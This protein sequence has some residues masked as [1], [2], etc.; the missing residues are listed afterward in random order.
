MQP[1]QALDE[2]IRRFPF[3]GYIR[4]ESGGHLDVAKT[5]R[6]FLE[7]G[8]KI[9]DFG[10]GP[11]DKTA[12]L[13]LMGYPCTAFDDLADDWIH[14]GE[15]DK[16]VA[17]CDEIGIVLERPTPD[18]GALPEALT[19]GGFD[20][21]ML[22][23]VLEHLHDSPRQ[24]LIDL[25]GCVKPNGLLYITVP[26]AV[27][28]R[29]RLDVLRGRTNA[30]AFEAYYW[31]RGPWRGHIREY[32]KRDLVLLARYLDLEVAELRGCHHM[33]EKAPPWL[34]LIY[35]A[36]TRLFPGWSDSWELVARKRPTWAPRS[37]LSDA[38]YERA[39]AKLA[40]T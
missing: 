23:D 13:Q 15:L 21:V 7:P 32:A 31:Y 11:C 25:L 3:E 24:L 8:A 19:R 36:A 39:V 10:A 14:Q 18:A 12:V 40:R 2:V 35:M 1:E 33:L 16:I 30:Q 28:I 20:M 29:K 17:F 6:R 37:D 22:H 26:S 38:E 27:N 34:R 4:P 9:L 5:V